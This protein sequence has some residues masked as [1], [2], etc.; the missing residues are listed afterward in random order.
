MTIEAPATEQDPFGDLSDWG[1]V[2]E[3]LEKMATGSQLDMC[4]PGLVRILRYKGNWRLKEE[5]LKRMGGIEVPSG[6]L[7]DQTLRVLTDDNLYYDARILAANGLIQVLRRVQKGLDRNINMSV[8]QA[9]LRLRTTPQPL[10]FDNVLKKLHS[11]VK[12]LAG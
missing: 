7:I 12:L 2:L 5:V 1:R 11:V 9:T 8:R 10:A 3:I 4:Q 6:E